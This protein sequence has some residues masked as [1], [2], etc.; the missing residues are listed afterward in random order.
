MEVVNNYLEYRK[1]KPQ[2]KDWKKAQDEKEAKRLAYIEK[3]GLTEEQKQYDIKR[4]KAVLS[5][6]D[7]MDEYSQTRAEDTE[8][9]LEPIAKSFAQLASILGFGVGALLLFLS[10]V[11]GF[12]KSVASKFK[13]SDFTLEF[14]IPTVCSVISASFAG[15]LC[16]VWS[17]KKE[18]EASRVGRHEAMHKELACA[19]H[20]AVLTDEQEKQRDEIAKTIKIDK[21]EAKSAISNTRGF[22]SFAKAAKLLFVKDEDYEKSKSEFEEKVAKDKLNF[23][24]VQLNEK[25][26]EDAKMDQQLISNVVEKIDIASQDYAENIE[27]ATGV[28]NTIAVGSGGLVGFISSKIIKN[29]NFKNQTLKAFLPQGIFLATTVALSLIGL[30]LQK[31]GSRVARYKVKQD[32][33]NNPEKLFY[34]DDEKAKNEDGSKFKSENKKVNIFKFLFQAIKDNKG[35]EQ[36]LKSNNV[37]IKQKRKALEQIKLTDEQQKRAEQLQNNVFKVFD[38]VDDNSQKYSESTEMLGEALQLGVGMLFSIFLMFRVGK[39]VN[40]S[41]DSASSLGETLKIALP[42]ALPAILINMLTTREQKNASRVADLL[43]LKQLEDVRNF[44]DYS[45]TKENAPVQQ[46]TD[47]PQNINKYISA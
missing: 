12:A 21:K 31:Q 17:A 13:I 11:R 36:H 5:A 9:A 10:P 28:L 4:A 29:I 42:V 20:F 14:A 37:E 1:N 38:R 27:L 44:A 18:V 35:Y 32:F 2:Y 24:T 25:Q 23:E 15:L 19:N 40:K 3:N 34:V 7:I 8:T 39:M 22:N 26:L 6:V 46:V 45:Q 43:A 30:K 33:L 16:S 41:L 47:K